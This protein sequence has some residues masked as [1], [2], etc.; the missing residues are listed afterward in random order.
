MPPFLLV[1][2]ESTIQDYIQNR[3]H[4]HHH[5]CQLGTTPDPF[6][7]LKKMI[8]ADRAKPNQLKTGSE[9]EGVDEG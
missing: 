8:I 6:A 1:L 2:G 5:Q 3:I 7:C 9:I 4:H